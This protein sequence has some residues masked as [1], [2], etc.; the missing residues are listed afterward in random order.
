LFEATDR[1]ARLSDD[2][3]LLDD[4]LAL[5]RGHR[6]DQSLVY[7]DEYAIAD[8]TMSLAEGVG[9][10]GTI[11]P[12]ALPLLF[13]LTPGRT[14]REAAQAAGVDTADAAPTIRHLLELGLLEQTHG[15]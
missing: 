2:T 9:V 15:S 6:L 1:L 14:P 7:V 12:A 5:V 10:V 13:E 8:V 3:E 11:E 4:E